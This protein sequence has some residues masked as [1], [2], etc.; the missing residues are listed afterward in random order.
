MENRRD[1]AAPPR[2]NM[3]WSEKHQM[4]T[5]P[6][7]RSPEE[8]RKHEAIARQVEKERV[9][10][11]A[12]KEGQ[13]WAD[14]DPRAK[15]RTMEVKRIEPPNAICVI[16]TNRDGWD[17]EKNYTPK[18]M[19]GREIKIKLRRFRPIQSGYKLIKDVSEA[20]AS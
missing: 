9:V 6:D 19:V 17:K 11:L 12:V 2:P 3:I 7:T 10:A 13:V 16:L 18:S 15:G 8:K 5:D 1:P 14:N 20:Q 4:W